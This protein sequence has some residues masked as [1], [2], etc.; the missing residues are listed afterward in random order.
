MS[1]RR[2]FIIFVIFFVPGVLWSLGHDNF[3]ADILWILPMGLYTQN[4]K[5]KIV[6]QHRL[7]LRIALTLLSWFFSFFVVAFSIDIG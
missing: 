1:I 4:Y 6:L 2:Y 3:L 7:G 5:G